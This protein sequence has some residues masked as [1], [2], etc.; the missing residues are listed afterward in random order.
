M[1]EILE[2]FRERREQYLL[3]FLMKNILAL[4]PQIPIC[5]SE[6]RRAGG[7]VDRSIG[8]GG[9]PKKVAPYEDRVFRL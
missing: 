7:Q 2:M 9:G 4:D 1:F 8:T 3:Q 6:N 5:E